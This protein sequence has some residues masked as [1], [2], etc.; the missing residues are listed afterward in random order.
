MGFA[1]TAFRVTGGCSDCLSYYPKMEPAPESNRVLPIT[2][3]TCAFLMAANHA[4]VI[5]LTGKI[6]W[7]RG[8]EF[9]LNQRNLIFNRSAVLTD[10]KSHRNIYTTPEY[11]MVGAERIALPWPRSQAE[12]PTNGPHSVKESVQQ[13]PGS[14]TSADALL[15]F[16]YEYTMAAQARQSWAALDGF[17]YAGNTVRALNALVPSS[18]SPGLLFV[19]YSWKWVQGRRLNPL[20]EGMNLSFYLI[21]Y[22]A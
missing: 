18:F 2:S 8:Q 20:Q 17:S 16:D 6:N 10:G 11:K 21:N 12:W 7:L 1:P 3:R 19:L 4:Y 9:H 14:T 22:P 5:T 13:E 15:Q